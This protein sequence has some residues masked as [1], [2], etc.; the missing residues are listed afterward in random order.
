MK[1]IIE[2]NKKLIEQLGRC[3]PEGALILGRNDQPEELAALPA[4]LREEI[5]Q[6]R[7]EI[8]EVV[9]NDFT[10][11][12]DLGDDCP[13]LMI[14]YEDGSQ[15]GFFRGHNWQL[16][17]SIIEQLKEFNWDAEREQALAG[18]QI[19]DVMKENAKHL[20]SRLP[21]TRELQKAFR[22]EMKEFL[23]AKRQDLRGVHALMWRGDEGVKVESFEDQAS[24]CRELP[25]IMTVQYLVIAVVADG[26]PMS[27]EELEIL[28]KKAISEL[29]DMPISHARALG[30]F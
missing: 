23:K 3:F 30:K 28:K 27:R 18:C 15:T 12:F 8:N 26:K 24:F 9:P 2:L 13:G 14:E 29:E 11:S 17:R 22:V 6:L 25:D 21:S 5:E 7:G 1:E 19:F 20:P 16:N 4:A 10:Y